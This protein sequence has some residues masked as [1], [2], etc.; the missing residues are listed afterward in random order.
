MLFMLPP[1]V[2]GMLCGDL[3]RLQSIRHAFAFFLLFEAPLL[4][5]HFN[6]YSETH[7][8]LRDGPSVAA[9]MIPMFLLMKTIVLLLGSSAVWIFYRL[10]D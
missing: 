3:A 8:A 2:I 6:A 4:V 1:F 10:R 7:R 9:S 5:M